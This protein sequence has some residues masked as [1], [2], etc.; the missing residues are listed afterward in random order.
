MLTSIHA[1]D[2]GRDTKNVK[3]STK[4]VW[5]GAPFSCPPWGQC[6]WAWDPPRRWDGAH[7]ELLLARLCT[8]VLLGLFGLQA[9]NFRVSSTTRDVSP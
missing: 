9:A 5:G 4:S 3:F 7:G 1:L 8:F 6:P 2:A